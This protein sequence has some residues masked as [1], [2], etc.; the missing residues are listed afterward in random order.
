V[1]AGEL[2][3]HVRDLEG[4]IGVWNHLRERLANDLLPDTSGPSAVKIPGVQDDH[5][6]NVADALDDTVD[7]LQKE[8]NK[9]MNKEVKG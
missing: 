6:E 5:I 4:R 8:L 2:L 3:L 9:L 1:R 7:K